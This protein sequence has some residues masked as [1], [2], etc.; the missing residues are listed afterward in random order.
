MGTLRGGSN[1]YPQ[2]VFWAEIWKSIRNFIWKLSVLDGE[3]FNIFE[4][5]CFRNVQAL[6]Q[7][8]QA[9]SMVYVVLFFVIIPLIPRISKMIVKTAGE[10][11]LAVRGKSGAESVY[12]YMIIAL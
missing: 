2:S 11:L 9:F 1:E 7:Y 5:A 6:Q 3:I 8:V 10:V 12:V 4:K